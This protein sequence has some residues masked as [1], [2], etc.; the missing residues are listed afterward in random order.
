MSANPIVLWV[1]SNAGAL[2]V[3]I[4]LLAE[5]IAE[6]KRF[7]HNEKLKKR[8]LRTGVLIIAFGVAV[9]IHESGKM[10]R[11]LAE[12]ITLAGQANERAEALGKE[13]E[14]LRATNLVLEAQA[15]EVLDQLYTFRQ[16]VPKLTQDEIR[17]F[18]N[19]M[20]ET[21][22]MRVS[23]VIGIAKRESQE[24]HDEL[25][26][27]FSAGPWPFTN[28]VSVA[29]ST[30]HTHPKLHLLI[31]TK[32]R[33]P[34]GPWEFLNNRLFRRLQLLRRWT[35]LDSLGDR[36]LIIVVRPTPPFDH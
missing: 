30:E 27:V 19:M 26:R 17:S 6:M 34:D 16:N 3:I 4:G 25:V 20:A 18:T 32:R 9:E 1:V 2:I 22:Y 33:V 29:L 28:R 21:T 8:I 14:Q 5:L 11:K 23:V 31:I 12:A 10:S 13:T 36:D 35:T 24:I 7:E 15:G